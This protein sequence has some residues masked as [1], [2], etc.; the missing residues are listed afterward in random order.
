[1][2]GIS[3]AKSLELHLLQPL[4]TRDEVRAGCLRAASSHL[5]AVCV[6]PAHVGIAAAELEGSD[7]RV[8][9]AIGFPYGQEA[10]TVKLA[11]CDRALRD[12][13]DELAVM[14]DHSALGEGGDPAAARAELD[15]VLEHAWWSAL[16]AARGRSELTVVLETTMLDLALLEPVLRRLHETPAGFLQTGSGHQ[17]RAVTEQHVRTLREHLPADIAIVAVGGVATHD[18]AAALLN[19]GAVRVG[20]GSAV[21][22]VEAERLARSTRPGSGTTG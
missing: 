19:A 11:A 17:P 14:L 13:A 16:N 1:M 21:S 8:R 2:S 5:A 7:T 12:G 10:P 9:A 6:W 4:V 18:D 20:S 3:L 15:R 22:I